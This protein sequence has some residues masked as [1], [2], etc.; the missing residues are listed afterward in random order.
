MFGFACTESEVYEKG[1]F[2][3]GSDLLSLTRS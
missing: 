1:S 3:A 2:I